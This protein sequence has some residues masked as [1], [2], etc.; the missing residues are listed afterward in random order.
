M[1]LQFVYDNQYCTGCKACQVACKDCHGLETGLLYRRVISEE[2]GAFEPAQGGGY[3][4]YVFARYTS[5]SCFHCADP[6]CMRHCPAGAITKKTVGIK[7][8]GSRTGD[9]ETSEGEIVILNSDLCVG[10][11]LC[12][13][14]CPHDAPVFNKRTG[15]MEKCDFCASLLEQGELPAC[16]NACP[17]RLIHVALSE[18]KL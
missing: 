11:G 4:N 9:G 17:M 8:C 10:C 16:V 14:L 18:E 12:K 5:I 6:V 3:V 1:Q 7:G 2:G 13:K 15:H